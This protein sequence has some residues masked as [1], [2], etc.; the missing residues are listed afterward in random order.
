MQVCFLVFRQVIFSFSQQVI[1]ITQ[2][3]RGFFGKIAERIREV[4]FCL[5]VVLKFQFG[6]THKFTGQ[7]LFFIPA[8]LT[9]Y[10]ACY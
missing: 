7:G 8:V 1:D 4:F 5:V 10:L 2:Y 9:A 3:F 6:F